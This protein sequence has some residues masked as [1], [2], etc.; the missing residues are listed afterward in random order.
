[1][2]LSR[3]V[4]LATALALAA[5]ALAPSSAAADSSLQNRIDTIARPAMEGLIR[6]QR[7]DGTFV[8]TTKGTVGGIGLTKAGFVAAHQSARLTPTAAATRRTLA[9]RVISRGLGGDNVLDKWAVALWAAEE[10]RSGGPLSTRLDAALVRL[11]RLHAPGI[12]DT[13]FQRA[14]CFNNYSLV[15]RVLDLEL[16]ASGLRSTVG[17][18]RLSRPGLRSEALRWLRDVLP[19][20]TSQS[21][22]VVVPGVG[23]R[24][25]AALSDPSRYPLA[26]QTLCTALLVRAARLGGNRTPA[27]VWRLT[28]AALWELVGMTAPN[29]EITWLGRGQDEVWTLAAN[30]YA[31]VEGSA[32]MARRD[33]QLAARLRRIA[34]IELEALTGRLTDTGLAQTPSAR[35][36][37]AG[38]DHYASAV[39]NAALALVWMELA[40]DAAPAVS[41]PVSPLPAERQGGRASDPE[42]NGLVTL[43]SG[44][45]WMGVHRRRDHTLDPRQD[46]G[47]LR[48]LWR[49]DNGRWISLLPA[50]PVVR[51]G[52]PSPSGGPLLVRGERVVTPVVHGGGATTRAIRLRGSWEGVPARFDYAPSR[53]GV[54]LRTTCPR[55]LALQFTVFLPAEGELSRSSTVLVRGGYGVRFSRPISAAVL[56]TRYGSAREPHLTA[57]RVR[58]RCGGAP[59]TVTYSG[60]AIAKG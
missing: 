56:P 8:D 40:R 43:R 24:S 59:L 57:I 21:A 60:T 11:G 16:A 25:A 3:P 42:G 58:V 33:P 10:R 37:R 26:Y 45:L 7:T 54:R 28:R 18:A 6:A 50:R 20:T 32:L 30:L 49:A 38:I 53:D 17:G 48:A 52:R 27:A 51:R 2:S 14:N 1:M 12:A 4:R 41:G 9:Q 29:G 5:A 22:R 46:F 55:G 36:G 19:Q 31:G 44:R 35:A 23:V 39:G 15:S 34:E 47:L 13:C